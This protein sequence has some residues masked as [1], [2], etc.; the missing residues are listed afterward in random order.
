MAH[1]TIA[2]SRYI[3]RDVPDEIA[4]PLMKARI[5]KRVVI[6]ETGCWEIKGFKT[7]W[8]YGELCFRGKN[9]F[10][11]RLTYMLWKGPIPD[12]LVVCHR[13]DNRPCVNPE[14]LFIGTVADNN[15]DMGAKGRTK[16]SAEIWTHCKHGHEFTPENT[17]VDKRGFRHCRICARAKNRRKAGWPEQLLYS[18]VRVPYGHKLCRET[19]QIVPHA[20]GLAQARHNQE[21]AHG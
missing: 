17:E 11:H 7:A 12:G 8:G 2:N 13:C 5:Q 15:R 16:Y 14:H 1:K 9:Y 3:G 10:A 18:D 19:W 6:T 21:K 4:F 20:S